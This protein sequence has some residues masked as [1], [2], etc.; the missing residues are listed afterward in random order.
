MAMPTTIDHTGK[1]AAVAAA[2]RGLGAAAAQA[3]SEA[4]ASVVIL[5]IDLAARLFE[6]PAAMEAIM[7]TAPLGAF[8]VPKCIGHAIAFLASPAACFIT[9]HALPVD[10]GWLTR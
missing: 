9:G 3:L 10:N 4:A 8:P 7:R 2:G 1:V 6:S 5:D